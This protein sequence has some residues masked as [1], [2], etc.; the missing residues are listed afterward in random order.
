[1]SRADKIASWH[2]NTGQYI[3]IKH[4]VLY[5]LLERV[6][7]KMEEGYVPV[8]GIETADEFYFQ[9]MVRQHNDDNRIENIITL[10]DND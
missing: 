5:L 6:N 4:N 3:V 2:N 1:M 7:A 10:L 9:A 8:G